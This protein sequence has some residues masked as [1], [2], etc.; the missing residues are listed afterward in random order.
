MK[1]KV[2][3]IK[4]IQLRFEWR[5]YGGPKIEGENRV[6]YSPKAAARAWAEDRS[7]LWTRKH[8]KYLETLDHSEYT[9]LIV[10]FTAK[11]YRRSLPIF[12]KLFN[13]EIK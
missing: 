7:E 10:A 11:A 9:P 8:T 1:I 12:T 3:L 5:V 6:Y 4:A 13:S 2:K